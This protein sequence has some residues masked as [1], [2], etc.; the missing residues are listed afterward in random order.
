MQ[1]PGPV[2]DPQVNTVA[3]ASN[4]IS[5]DPGRKYVIV[6]EYDFYF[7]ITNSAADVVAPA[8]NGMLWPGMTPL[9]LATYDD[10]QYLHVIQRETGGN[11]TSLEVD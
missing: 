4:P 7:R 5:L 10:R 3:A 9:Y 8:T 11:I 1:I 6:A 2:S